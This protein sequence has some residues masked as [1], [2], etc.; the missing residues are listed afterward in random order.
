MHGWTMNFLKRLHGWLHGCTAVWMWIPGR[1]GVEW[2]FEQL[3]DGLMDG[4]MDE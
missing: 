1:L 4:L 2:I 3:M